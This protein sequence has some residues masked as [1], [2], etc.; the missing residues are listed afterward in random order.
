MSQLPSEARVTTNIAP[1]HYG[2]AAM[3]VYDSKVDAGAQSRYNTVEDTWQV[4]KMT[5]YIQMDDD[6]LRERKIEFPFYRS[7]D[8]PP[9]GD[10]L[11]FEDTLME[12]SAA[13]AP[14]Y[15]KEGQC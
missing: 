13:I 10:E 9:S 1:K 5:W 15:P 2:V 7:W 11:V 8:H 14:I 6:L 12:S 3:S 4:K